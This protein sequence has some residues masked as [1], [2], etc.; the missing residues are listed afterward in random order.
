MNTAFP[1]SCKKRNISS[2]KTVAVLVSRAQFLQE[3]RRIILVLDD[4][5]VETRDKHLDKY[6][7][8]WSRP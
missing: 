2:T 1:G 6:I 3:G 4:F 8:R 7:V 5:H